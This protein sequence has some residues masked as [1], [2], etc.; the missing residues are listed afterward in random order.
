MP[1]TIDQHKQAILEL[2][3]LILGDGDTSERSGLLGRRYKALYEDTHDGEARS[4]FL[5]KAIFSFERAMMLDARDYLPLC[6]LPRLY[7]ERQWDGDEKR[8]V[9]AASIVLLACERWRQRNPA[10]PMPA[11][12]ELGAAF[13]MGDIVRAEKLLGEMRAQTTPAL[14]MLPANIPD[15]RRSLSLLDDVRTSSALASVLGGLQRLLDPNGTV[16]A[17]AGRRIDAAGAEERRF[18]PE[19]EAMIAVRIR[20]MMVAAASQAVVCSAASG[21]DILALEGAA[22]LGLGRRV[23]LP[24]S[25]QQFRATSVADR[26][27]DWGRRFDAILQQMQSKDVLELNLQ[28]GDNVA[29]AA[30]NS[31]IIDE[32]LGWASTTGRRPLAMVVWNGFSRGATDLTDG[33][34][35]VAVDRRLEV[36]PVPTL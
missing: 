17:L 12:M 3:A 24:F 23:V 28:S 35:G 34:R 10:D 9:T 16:L 5:N 31:K 22:Q 21:A 11:Y 1:E 20:N 18:P 2:E 19:N 33:F 6:H 29:Y 7:R 4:V 30:V 25:R 32:A 27:E 15:L 8:A 14:D 13:D 36:I 26:G